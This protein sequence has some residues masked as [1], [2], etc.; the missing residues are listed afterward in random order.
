MCIA[1]FHSPVMLSVIP[2]SINKHKIIL[3]GDFLAGIFISYRRVDSGGRVGR[4]S[5]YFKGYYKRNECFI[6]IYSL[7]PG[8]N[9]EEKIEKSLQNSIVFLAV[10]GPDWMTLKDK[11]NKLLLS[12][13]NDFVRREILTALNREN[14]LIVPV[15]VGGAKIPSMND[16]PPKLRQ[17]FEYQVMEITDE[18]WEYDVGLSLIHI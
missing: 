13:E 7:E 4:L 11:D 8:D 5:D 6:D 1:R 3:N 15:L 12:K 16:L 17:L 18:R 9:F 2:L 10:V 14:L